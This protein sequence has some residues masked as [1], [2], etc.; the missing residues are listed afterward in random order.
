ML[1]VLWVAAFCLGF[2]FGWGLLQGDL[3]VTRRST[4][5]FMG[6]KGVAC[7]YVGDTGRSSLRLF[8]LSIY[9]GSM[10]SLQ[11]TGILAG[12]GCCKGKSDHCCHD[13][14]R[15]SPM[16]RGFIAPIFLV[17]L[18]RFMFFPAGPGATKKESLKR[19]VVACCYPLILVLF[20]KQWNQ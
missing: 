3:L 17:F 2:D 11:T 7:I 1:R 9:A 14:L 12:S 5:Q 8:H 15:L 13:L 19:E 20:A 4:S 16:I 6:R 18:F 10:N